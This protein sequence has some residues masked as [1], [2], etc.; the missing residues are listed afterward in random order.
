VLLL[1]QLQ[2]AGLLGPCPVEGLHLLLGLLLLLWVHGELQ[3]EVLLLLL[4]GLRLPL[5]T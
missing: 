5:C 3:Q 4:L 2:Q 1:Q